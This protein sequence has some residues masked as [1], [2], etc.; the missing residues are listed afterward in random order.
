MLRAFLI[1]ISLRGFLMCFAPW[2]SRA[3]LPQCRAWHLLSFPLI[4]F[5]FFF[6]DCSAFGF[7]LLFDAFPLWWYSF[8]WFI[9]F[10]SAAWSLLA[11]WSFLAQSSFSGCGSCFIVFLSSKCNLCLAR[12]P[13]VGSPFLLLRFLPQSLLLNQFAAFSNF[14]FATRFELI[15]HPNQLIQSCFRLNQFFFPASL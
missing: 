3:F 11:R 10:R 14:D 12:R 5:F 6:R 4:Q 13:S 8:A 2:L 7:F 1:L 9:R 15:N